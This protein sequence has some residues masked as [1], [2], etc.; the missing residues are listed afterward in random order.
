MEEKTLIQSLKE[1][2]AALEVELAK[3]EAG[4]KNSGIKAK[5]LASNIAVTAKAIRE[6]VNIKATASKPSKPAR[7]ALSDIEV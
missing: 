7:L 2:V 3:F 6:D 5:N 1:E 4:S